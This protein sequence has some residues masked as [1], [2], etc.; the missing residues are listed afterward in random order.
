MAVGLR[1]VGTY[2]MV[3]SLGAL[4]TK[5]EK[6]HIWSL[7]DLGFERDVALAALLEAG[8]DVEAATDRLLCRPPSVPP[9]V[10]EEEGP[11]WKRSPGARLCKRRLGGL[12]PA[13]GRVEEQHPSPCVERCAAQG[14]AGTLAV[15]GQQTGR[16]QGVS[17]TST[18]QRIEG[19]PPAPGLALVQLG[20]LGSTPGSRAGPLDCPVQEA[21]HT[22]RDGAY[23]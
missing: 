7:L 19:A 11:R 6:S 20:C 10:L 9:V 17:G 23:S 3:A 4:F 5:E 14:S 21:Q 22:H 2:T 16:S 13:A 18:C 12:G 15:C 1:R 8:W